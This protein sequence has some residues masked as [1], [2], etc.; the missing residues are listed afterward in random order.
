MENYQIKLSNF[1]K[2]HHSS[3]DADGKKKVET[4]VEE[5][6]AAGFGED[7]FKNRIRLLTFIF[8]ALSLIFNFIFTVNLTFNFTSIFSLL[9]SLLITFIFTSTLS[10]T[11]KF[12]CIVVFIFILNQGVQRKG[13]LKRR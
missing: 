11:S 13:G 7:F 5:E 1:A 3:S 6:D 2:I 10:F 12:T 4:F 8:I 9:L